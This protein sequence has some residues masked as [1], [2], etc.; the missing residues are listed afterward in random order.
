MIE[1][2]DA[3]VRKAIYQLEHGDENEENPRYIQ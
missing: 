2:D 1:A 3:D